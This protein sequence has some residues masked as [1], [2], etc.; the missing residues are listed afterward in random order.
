MTDG[1]PASFM[2]PSPFAL[3]NSVHVSVFSSEDRFKTGPLPPLPQADFHRKHRCNVS[4]VESVA[5][6]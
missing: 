4:A 6:T 2:F 3:E 1:P 5:E